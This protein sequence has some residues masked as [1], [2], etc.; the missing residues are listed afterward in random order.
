VGILDIGKKKGF[1]DVVSLFWFVGFVL[2][3]KSKW[4]GWTF[5]FVPPLTLMLPTIPITLSFTLSLYFQFPTP[6]K[7][8]AKEIVAQLTKK[9]DVALRR[10]ASVFFFPSVISF[11]ARRCASLAL[12]HVVEMDSCVK[13]DVTRL[14][15][16]A[17]RWEDLRP[18]W[19]YFIAPPAMLVKRKE[20]YRVDRERGGCMRDIEIRRWLE[21][22]N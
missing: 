3:N 12:G 10:L 13:R 4:V 15:R 22:K 9:I 21:T 19:R 11:S 7:G 2:S 16:R 8:E 1:W 6:A 17:C 5:C 18:R 14:R 20:N